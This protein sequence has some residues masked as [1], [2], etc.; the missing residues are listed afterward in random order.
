MKT[1]AVSSKNRN[2]AFAARVERAL[3]RAGASARR[4]ARM[5]GTAVYVLKGGRIVAEKP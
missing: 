4:T 5:H 1:K 3:I 2:P